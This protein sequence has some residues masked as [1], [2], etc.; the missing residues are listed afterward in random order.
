MRD[1]DD[2]GVTR[3][4]DRRVQGV[5]LIAMVVIVV[6]GVV[7]AYHGG[8]GSGTAASVEYPQSHVEVSVPT[9]DR[10]RFVEAIERFV[11]SRKLKAWSGSLAPIK[12]STSTFWTLYLGDHGVEMRAEIGKKGQFVTTFT[13]KG[14]NGAE[15]T[16]GRAF[17]TDVVEAGGFRPLP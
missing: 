9:S 17:R 14:R 11:T 13:D 12:E 2:D 8:G 16:L 6:A 4:R 3:E 5:I 10:S 15:Q 1:R 7:L